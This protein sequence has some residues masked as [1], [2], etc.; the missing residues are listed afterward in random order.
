RQTY[1]LSQVVN[2]AHPLPPGCT[3]HVRGV[4]PGASLVALK[5][6]GQTTQPL[7]SSF[8]QAIERAVMVDHVDVID[9]SLG[10]SPF[11]DPATDPIALA[12]EAAAAAGVVVVT[13]SDDA[14]ATRTAGSP[15]DDAGVIGVGAATSFRV[16]RQATQAASPPSPRRRPPPHPS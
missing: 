15:S 9:H 3:V 8:L 5:V 13:S 16:Y 7:T 12:D 2:P 10:A 1:D 4:A 11:P 6:F 14:G